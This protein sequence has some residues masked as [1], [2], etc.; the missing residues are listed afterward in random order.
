MNMKIPAFAHIPAINIYPY[1]LASKHFLNH[2]AF[3]TL[4]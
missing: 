1:A 2:S 3:T 4:K